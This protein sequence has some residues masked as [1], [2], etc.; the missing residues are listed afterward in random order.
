VQGLSEFPG[1]H[2]YHFGHREA[3]A[4]KKLSCRHHTREDRVDELLRG[5]VLVDL[6]TVVRQSLVAGI[7]SYTLKQLEALHGFERKF[8][9]RGAARAMQLFGFWLET[10]DLSRPDP[11]LVAAI[12]G[13]NEED[14]L[15]TWKLR[16]W[17]ELQRVELGKQVGRKLERPEPADPKASEAR[18]HASQETA[19]LARRL[20]ADLPAEPELD[21]AE[22]RAR[23]LL[24]N[25]LDWHWREEKSGWWEYYRAKE[26]APAERVDD[27]AVLGG[28]RFVEE[29]API[30]QSRV[31]RYEFPEQEHAIRALGAE[32]PDTGK[33]AGAIVEIGAT[34]IVLRRGK[35]SEAPHPTALV[36]VGPVETK[37]QKQRLLELG[38]SIASLGFSSARGRAERELLLRNPPR[39]GA[40]PGA[41]LL[42][43]GEDTVTGIQR[44]ALA[45]DGSVLPIQGPPGSGKTHRAAEM[46][47]R[48]VK[49]KKRVGVTAN[50][51]KVITSLL[52]KALETGSRH[53]VPLRVRH[54][55]DST[56][57]DVENL[58]FEVSKDY[59][60]V[61]NELRRGELDV[62]G[63]T[64]WAWSRA[65]FREI[66]DYLVVDEAGQVSLANALAVAGAANNLILFGD[67]AQLDQPQK[68]AHPP[69]A[70]AS[71]FEH[72]LGDALTLAPER[73]VFLPETRRLHPDVCRF[74]SEVFY[75]GRLEPT[76][77]LHRQRVS[78]PGVFDGSGLRFV[79]VAH[80]GNTNRA[81]EEVEVIAK[82]LAEL[83]ARSA[84]FTDAHGAIHPITPADVLVVAPYNAQVAALKRGLP[85][86]VHVGTVDKFQGQQAPIVIYSMTSSSAADAPRGME[87]LYNLNRLNVATSRAQ[88]LVVLTASPELALVRCRTPRQIRL[89]NA[90]CRYLE[91]ARAR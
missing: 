35:N 91:L 34:E 30:K 4:L 73:G 48:L 54:I 60:R 78:G 18:E 45:L 39:V 42:A 61:E 38:Q 57:F 17:L 53:G 9:L 70:E 84:E 15:S 88:A 80:R 16:E 29:L 72:L 83:F 12:Q 40:A 1:L 43:P 71:A 22:Q 23:R 5:R 65:G 24:S 46:I 8:D 68:G 64:A 27:R 51:H 85:A 31:F 33:S 69:G 77:D 76:P 81:D 7:E 36:A 74:T 19:A 32:D 58:P 3:D 82:L 89:V 59:D 63:G 20:C 44:L 52:A 13:Y 2:V 6:H 49:E 26:L 55:G 90:L 41:P 25:L 79:P 75:E 86:R 66:V 56:N 47:V 14:C 28:L 87:F 11:E 10:S 37:S 50:S 62:V 21:D 67:P